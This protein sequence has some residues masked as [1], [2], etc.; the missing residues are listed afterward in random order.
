M[1]EF[2]ADGEELGEGNAGVGAVGEGEGGVE[3]GGVGGILLGGAEA[4]REQPGGGDAV[5][6]EV[7]DEAV[8]VA[9][10]PA[11]MLVGI[12][13]ARGGG[14]GGASVRD[15]KAGA[16]LKSGAGAGRV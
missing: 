15:R 9:L 4:P 5:G 3:V 10:V 12:D 1:R 13:D 11:D 16:K 7:G 6:V 8:F 14:H 2:F